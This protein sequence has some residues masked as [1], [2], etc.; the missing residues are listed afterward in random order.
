MALI[1][2]PPQS[3]AQAERYQ[4]LGAID[5]ESM[6]MF[7]TRTACRA[8]GQQ[9]WVRAD[10]VSA[11][12][13]TQFCKVSKN[14]SGSRFEFFAAARF[15]DLAPDE[16][17]FAPQTTAGLSAHEGLLEAQAGV[18]LAEGAAGAVDFKAG[19]GITTGAGIK[20]DSISVKVLGIGMI[21]GRKCGI[22]SRAVRA[23][24][25]CQPPAPPHD[26]R[27]C[28]V[29]RSPS[30][31]TRS[32]SISARCS[33]RCDRTARTRTPTWMQQGRG[34][35]ATSRALRSAPPPQPLPRTHPCATP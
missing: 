35:R 34:P 28:G 15:F 18:Q 21:F 19:L 10:A 4:V 9:P 31:T 25:P 12:T 27:G 8:E 17:G 7:G 11:K 26:A 16:S 30:W 1:L 2:A 22:V 5:Y 24:G 3:S 23:P 6:E 20:D 13:A 29:R 33:T 14:S 32:R